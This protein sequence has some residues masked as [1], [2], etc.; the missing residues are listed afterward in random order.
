MTEF[1][2]MNHFDDVKVWVEERDDGQAI[3]R[4]RG[5][6]NSGQRVYLFDVRRYVSDSNVFYVWAGAERFPTEGIIMFFRSVAYK[7]RP[8]N[9]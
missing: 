1:G 5:S 9:R 8:L 3:G 2:R 6:V 7:G 4:L